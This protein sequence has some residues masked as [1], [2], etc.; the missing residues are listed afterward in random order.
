MSRCQQFAVVKELQLEEQDNYIARNKVDFE[1]DDG[2][3]LTDNSLRRARPGRPDYPRN[4]VI[5]SLNKHKRWLLPDLVKEGVEKQYETE[6]KEIADMAEKDRTESDKLRITVVER[7]ASPYVGRGR[8]DC[9]GLTSNCPTTKPTSVRKPTKAHAHVGDLISKRDSE[10]DA[11]LYYEFLSPYPENSWPGHHQVKCCTGYEVGEVVGSKSK[12]K[13]KGRRN[14]HYRHGVPQDE[15]IDCRSYMYMDIH[16]QYS[17]EQYHMNNIHEYTT[18]YDAI[19]ENPGSDFSFPI[20]ACIDAAI[21]T[22]T[23]SKNNYLPGLDRCSQTCSLGSA[24][25]FGKGDAIY[26]ESA[27]GESL[28]LLFSPDE[29]EQHPEE[30]LSEDRKL[31]IQILAESIHPNDLKQEFGDD[32]I[33]DAILPRKFIINADLNKTLPNMFTND[34]CL[35]F[36]ISDVASMSEAVVEVQVTLLLPTTN[37]LST[38]NVAENVELELMKLKSSALLTVK[39]TVSLIAE[40]IVQESRCLP[41][42][43][44]VRRNPVNPDTCITSVNFIHDICQEKPEICLSK[45][46]VQ[47]SM[48]EVDNV[49]NEQIPSSGDES[50]KKTELLCEICLLDMDQ[51]QGTVILELGLHSKFIRL[52]YPYQQYTN[53]LY[54]D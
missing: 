24:H 11:E 32:Y 20:G 45:Q 1:F 9:F 39:D 34:C 54:F 22:K 48:T 23:S 29:K 12:K 49:L 25:Q 41:K 33:E 35:L 38:E 18:D 37:E 52:Y 21:K 13:S 47:H 2:I 43:S 15:P 10:R 31:N 27:D 4:P 14:K 7:H 8:G 51:D 5:H 44:C 17:H 53:F 6:N 19:S 26:L 46:A 36:E 28:G 50:V 3:P 30:W 42:G 16:E 40:K